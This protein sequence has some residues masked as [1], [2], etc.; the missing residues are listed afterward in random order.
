MFNPFADENCY[1]LFP[2]TRAINIL[3]NRFGRLNQLGLFKPEPL[4]TDIVSI[5]MQNYVIRLLPSRP[6]GSPG[7]QSEH[8]KRGV[9][10]FKVPHI[11]LEDT[12]R[13]EHYAGVRAF[14]T[15]TQAETLANVMA[16]FL[17][18]NRAKFELTWEHLKWG[19]LKG[20]IIDGDG[21]TPLYNLFTE[22]GI[23]QKTVNFALSDPET[24]VQAKCFEVS[25]HI[26]ENLKGD[27]SSGVRVMVSQEFFDAL[28]SHP[29]VLKFFLNQSEASQVS[30]QDI[31]KGFRFGGLVFEEHLG[32]APNGG[33]GDIQRFIAEGEGHAFPEGTAATFLNAMAP[34]DFLETVNTPGVELYAKQK[35]KD[36][37]KGVDLWF[38]SNVLPICLRP[39]VLVKVVK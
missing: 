37:D 13:P 4:T 27:I 3:P 34:G 20:L 19:A 38:E 8:G 32:K 14:G 39:G 33:T 31:R 11:P 17:F 23:Q 2:L 22:F 7:S 6:K 10:T 28:T 25:R 1:G 30:G 24:N 18:E 9:L 5:E 36:F 35:L 12:I 15:A 29:N 16:R 26:E 21:V